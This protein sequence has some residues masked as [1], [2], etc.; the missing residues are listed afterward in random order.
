MKDLATVGFPAIALVGREIRQCLMV[1]D[2]AA[3]PAGYRIFRHGF[4]DFWHSRLA[5]IFLREYIGSDLTPGLGHHDIVEAKDD[6]AI[7]IAN[8]RANRLK[9]KLRK[10]IAISRS[11]EG[12]EFH[13]IPLSVIVPNHRNEYYSLWGRLVNKLRLENF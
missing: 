12:C 2:A 11:I 7:A 9:P 4:E 6:R 1:S 10:R 3:K 13:F 8:L 5:E